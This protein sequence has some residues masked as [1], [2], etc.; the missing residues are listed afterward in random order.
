[1]ANQPHEPHSSSNSQDVPANIPA[2]PNQ[3]RP[4]GTPLLEGLRSAGRLLINNDRGSFIDTIWRD[5]VSAL[6]FGHSSPH[7]LFLPLRQPPEDV[8]RTSSRPSSH[9]SDRDVLRQERMSPGERG[10]HTQ[11]SPSS[12]EIARQG[13]LWSNGCPPLAPQNFLLSLQQPAERVEQSPNPGRPPW[14]NRGIIR[15]EQLTREPPEDPMNDTQPNQI[16]SVL[17]PHPSSQTPETGTGEDT[18]LASRLRPRPR[19]KYRPRV[20]VTCVST[21]LPLSRAGKISS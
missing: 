7:L 5:I 15:Q 10:H 4:R 16:S 19:P 6:G 21:Q 18:V 11:S 13:V 17:E 8:E 20:W 1:M 2:P 3:P 9:R 14:F 12:Q